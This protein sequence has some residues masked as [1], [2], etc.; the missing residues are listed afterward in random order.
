MEIS[1][2]PTEAGRCVRIDFLKSLQSFITSHQSLSNF[3]SKGPQ[4]EQLEE[5]W[6]QIIIY[7]ASTS[8]MFS[9]SAGNLRV[10]SSGFTWKKAGAGKSVEIQQGGTLNSAHLKPYLII[11]LSCLQSHRIC[12]CA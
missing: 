9:Q 4:C 6:N 3:S 5:L 1:F 8:L 2:L 12:L 7:D 10:S 11:A